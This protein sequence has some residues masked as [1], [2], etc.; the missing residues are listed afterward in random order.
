MR[1][2]EG[3]RL[4]PGVEIALWRD[5]YQAHRTARVVAGLAGALLVWPVARLTA[6]LQVGRT[7]AYQHLRQ[8]PTVRL[9]SLVRV[10]E[11]ALEEYIRTLTEP[12]ACRPITS[13]SAARSTTAGSTTR[14]AASSGRAPAA[15]TAEPPP[16]S[17][18]ALSERLKAGV[19]RL[20]KSSRTH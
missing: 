5:R 16:G 4:A 18:S 6:R 9:G 14:R 11:E 15:P 20:K 2:A 13:T 1:D 3:Y 17:A 19:W 10:T 7:L 8:M 12:P